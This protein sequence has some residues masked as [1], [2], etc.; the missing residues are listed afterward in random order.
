MSC[1]KKCDFLDYL[2]IIRDNL[3]SQKYLC[4]HFKLVTI[5]IIIIIIIIITAIELS[6]D[7]SSPY[8]STD[9]TNR[10]KYT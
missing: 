4:F 3:K 2:V 10:N 1:I 5:I 7:G 6:L 8:T 9:K